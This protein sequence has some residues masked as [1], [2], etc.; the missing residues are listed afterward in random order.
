MDDVTIVV[1][2]VKDGKPGKI[3]GSSAIKN[4]KYVV[5]MG[6]LP[7][8]KYVVM[9]NPGTSGYMPGERL[10]EYPGREGSK[11]QNWTISTMRIA[12]PQTE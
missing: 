12:N 9:V 8:G 1:R 4:G 3:V 7:A 10:I 5:N 11:E 6:D 2:L